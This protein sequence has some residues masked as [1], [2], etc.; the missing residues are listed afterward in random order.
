MKLDIMNRAVEGLFP[1]QFMVVD[2]PAKAKLAET[3]EQFDR[4]VHSIENHPFQQ[5]KYYNAAKKL[6]IAMAELAYARGLDDGMRIDEMASNASSETHD[7]ARNIKMKNEKL[8]MEKE[9]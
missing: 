9:Q 2:S 8:Q 1:E 3:R 6:A 5:Y 4:V 7:E